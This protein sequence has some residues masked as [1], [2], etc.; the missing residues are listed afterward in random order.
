MASSGDAPRRVDP[1]A[2]ILHARGRIAARLEFADNPRRRI[3]HLAEPDVARGG[4]EEGEGGAVEPPAVQADAAA[5]DD[6][7]VPH[8]RF[9]AV[10]DELAARA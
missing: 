6:G 4:V 2:V 1:A 3:G 9:M 7:A 5:V 8:G 10:A